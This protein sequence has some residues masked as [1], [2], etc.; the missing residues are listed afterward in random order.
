MAITTH[1]GAI[2]KQ[3]KWAWGTSS[4]QPLCQLQPI[5]SFLH[6]ALRMVL[7]RQVFS[8]HTWTQKSLW[9]EIPGVTLCSLD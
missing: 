2:Q 4:L 3:R 1:T 9:T 5:T 8:D 7:L 6:L